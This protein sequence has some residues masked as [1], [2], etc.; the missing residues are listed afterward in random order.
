LLKNLLKFLFVLVIAYAVGRFVVVFKDSMLTGQREPYVQMLSTNSVIIHWLTE[1]S[2]IGVVR[3]GE[4]S[5]HTAAI[6]IEKTATQNHIVKLSNLKPAT[7]YYYLTGNVGGFQE[8]DKNK[9]WFYTHPEEEVATRIWVL[10]DPG[11]AGKILNQVRDSALTWMRNNPEQGETEESPLID[12]WIA[13]GDIAYRSGSNKQFQTAL[14][15]TFEDITA[16]TVLWPIY[17]NHDERRWTYFRIFDL[18]E[19]AEAGGLASGTENYYA[20]DYSNVHFV[21]L[22][23]MSSDLT[24]TGDMAEWLRKDLAQNTKQ[25]VIAAFHHPPYSKGSHDSDDAGDSRG[26]MH[27][28]RENIIPILEQAGVDVVLAG[29]S[30]LYERSY[31]VDCAYETSDKFS[32]KNIVSDG[33]DGKHKKY[34]KP[35]NN[36]AN[37]G[38]VYVVTGSASKVDNGTLDHPAHHIGLK[39]A[40][41]VV[42]DVNGNKLVAR[43]INN[44]GKVRDE[45]NI[46]KQ[47]GY[48]S[49]YQ[50]CIN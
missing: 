4:N 32:E 1:E 47:A 31:L 29:H 12:I 17:G 37:Q 3:Y 23:S 38:A 15:D 19:N 33:V 39:E 6:E 41:S 16:N 40:G 30:H 8:M 42:I 36:R 7:R 35:L 10:G 5:E 46:T 27:D 28:I 49:G 26:R 22:D 45:F 2:H 21:M 34:I 24:A 11:S 44:K 50:G 14:F 25:W 43:F 18:P 13:L 20:I 48:S 9:H